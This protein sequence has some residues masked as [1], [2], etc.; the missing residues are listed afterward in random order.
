MARLEEEGAGKAEEVAR[1][2]EEEEAGPSPGAA[3]V[4]AQTSR[5]DLKAGQVGV[6]KE[7]QGN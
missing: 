1:S 2:L 3:A 5:R 4:G 6:V 7:G